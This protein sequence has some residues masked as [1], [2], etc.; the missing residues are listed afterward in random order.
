MG[1]QVLLETNRSPSIF[2]C[3]V[4]DEFPGTIFCR[5]RRAAGVV[6]TE[7]GAEVRGETDV[8]LISVRFA[9]KD[10]DVVHDG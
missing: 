9:A 4:C 10:V 5:V 6:C 7:S 8:V 2:E 3:C 1:F